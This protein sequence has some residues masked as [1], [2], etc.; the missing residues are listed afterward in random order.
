MRINVKVSKGHY[1]DGVLVL[2]AEELQVLRPHE[3]DVKERDVPEG[4]MGGG[5]K[6]GR[7]RRGFD[8]EH[9]LTS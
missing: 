5:D 1:L 9:S 4:V 7:F 2:H 3:G 8:G 6:R